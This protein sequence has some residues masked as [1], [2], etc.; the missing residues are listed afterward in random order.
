MES[1]VIFVA[2]SCGNTSLMVQKSV[3]NTWDVIPNPVKKW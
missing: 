1:K 2:G 3:G